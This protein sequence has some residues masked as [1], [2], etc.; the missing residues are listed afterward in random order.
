MLQKLRDMIRTVDP[1][2]MSPAVRQI[3]DQEERN[4]RRIANRIRYVF[5]VMIALAVFIIRDTQGGINISSWMLFVY[6]VTTVA[7]T[8]IIARSK[9]PL[10]QSVAQYVALVVDYGV[11]LVTLLYYTFEASPDNFGFATK[12]PIFY[13]FFLPLALST[14]LFRLRPVLIGVGVILLIYAGLVTQII[15]SGVP[16]TENWTEYILGPAVIVPDLLSTRI[17]VILGLGLV[18]SYSIYRALRMVQRIAAIEAQKTSLAR[19]FSPEVVD[20]ITTSPDV[21]RKGGRQAVTVLFTDIRD[22]TRMSEGMDAL[23]LAEFLSEFRGRMSAAIF[24]NGGTLDK[25]IGDAIMAT[26]GTPRPSKIAGQDASNALRAARGMLAALEKFNA[27]RESRGLAPVRIGIGLHSGEAF[28]GNVG[29]EDRL[30]FT[31]IGDAV[32]TASRIE[33]LCKKLNA[34][35][36]ISEAVFDQA[37]RPEDAEKMPRVRVKGK[38]DPLQVYRIA[39][40]E[41]DRADAWKSRGK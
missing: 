28:A 31:V 1:R 3:L 6:F 38:V 39:K 10:L 13:F 19:Y 18:F 25:F 40:L 30:E 22:F 36:L 2:Q 27:E 20:E 21:L 34:T 24:E 16:Q 12:N 8:I 26:F 17:V 33:S 23:A 9:S 5:I 35:L 37:G 7:H 15:I 29:S 4:G 11:F 41:A 32:N 14:L